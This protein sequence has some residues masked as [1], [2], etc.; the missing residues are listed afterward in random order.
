MMTRGHGC[1]SILNKVLC[2]NWGISL[3]RDSKLHLAVFDL[4]SPLALF[5]LCSLD[6]V[7]MLLIKMVL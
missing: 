4:Y 1:H 6:T 2:S 3:T 5:V 7:V